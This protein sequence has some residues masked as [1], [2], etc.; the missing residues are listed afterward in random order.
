MQAFDVGRLRPDTR[1]AQSHPEQRASDGQR[2]PALHEL[3]ELVRQRGARHVRF[4]IETKVSPLKPELTPEPEAFA[5]AVLDVA[6]RHAMLE[7]I[8]LQSFDWR[9]LGAAQR[10]APEVPTV[11]L[12]AQQS[13]A[14]NVADP[15]WTA[16]LELAKHGSVPRMVKAAGGAIWS[17]FFR[18]LDAALLREAHE[19]GLKVIVWTVNEPEDIMKMLDLGV[20]GII[21]DRPDRVRAALASRGKA[22]PAQVLPA[23]SR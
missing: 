18:D 23:Y 13:W 11:Y 16:G 19:L 6:R 21:S 15:R 17:P 3:F 20:D 4:N 1:Y 10:I 22:L 7:R 8:T 9:T 14:N 12:S 2:I 5:R